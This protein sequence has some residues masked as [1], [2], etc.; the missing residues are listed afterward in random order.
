[1]E[2]GG[3]LKGVQFR[4]T[5]EK[6]RRLQYGWEFLNFGVLG[7]NS[8]VLLYLHSARSSVQAIICAGMTGYALV[9]LLQIFLCR[10]RPRPRRLELFRRTKKVFR[11]VYTAIYLTTIMLDIFAVSQRPDAAPLLACYGA[12]FCWV[13]LWGTNCFWGIALW[14]RVRP[15]ICR[16]VRP[17]IEQV[18]AYMAGDG[19]DAL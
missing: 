13:I 6:R 5:P 12:L 19:G 15:V 7:L 8:F 4:L 17:I 18:L 16:I 2:P 10:G 14:R 11:L 9:L 3:L 1:M